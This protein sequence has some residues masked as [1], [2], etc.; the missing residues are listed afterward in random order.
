[1]VRFDKRNKLDYPLISQVLYIFIIIYIYLRMSNLIIPS[2][3]FKG[4]KE[5]IITFYFV[6]S[7]YE[8]LF[9][10]NNYYYSYLIEE[11]L[12]KHQ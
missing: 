8:D 7:F 9:I 11:Y 3:L 1:M 4:L 5:S 2:Y 12:L 6:K 10:L